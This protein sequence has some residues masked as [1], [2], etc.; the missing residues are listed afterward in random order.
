MNPIKITFLSIALLTAFPL[1]S[2]MPAK[3]INP[4]EFEIPEIH[5]VPIKDAQADLEGAKK[6]FAIFFAKES[7]HKELLKKIHQTSC[8]SSKHWA[9]WCNAEHYLE[10]RRQQGEPQA[11]LDALHNQAQ[12]VKTLLTQSGQEYVRLC[13]QARGNVDQVWSLLCYTQRQ[14]NCYR[15]Q[16]QKLR[17]EKEEWLKEKQR[18][19]AENQSLKAALQDQQPGAQQIEGVPHQ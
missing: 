2:S 13:Q 15:A 6:R 17:S 16:A 9:N 10:S 11:T 19:Q 18:M 1:F 8:E 7:P 14:R 4:D 3:A 5:L 12:V